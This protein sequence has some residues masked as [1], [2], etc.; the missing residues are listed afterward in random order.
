MRTLR[1]FTVGAL[2]ALVSVGSLA[3]GCDLNPYDLSERGQN[4]DDDDDGGMGDDGDVGDDGGGGDDGGPG[5]S[6]TPIGVDDQCNEIDDDCDGVT[7]QGF[8]KQTNAN[9]CGVCNNRCIGTGAIQ[10]CEAGACAFDSCQPGFTDLDA[11]PLDC[12]YRCPQFPTIA[13]DCNGIDDDCNGIIDDN[14]PPPP[15]NECRNTANT[16]CANVTMVCDTRNAITQWYCDYS[17]DVEFDANVPDGI[18]LNETLC[19]GLDGDCDGAPDDAFPDKGDECDNGLFGVCRDVGVRICDTAMPTQT[20][21]DL[22]VL[23][24]AG[25]MQPETCN[26]LD[27]NCDNL[28]DNGATDSMT[29]VTFAG[30]DFFI[31]TY[32]ASHPDAT[33]TGTGVSTVRSCSNPGVLPWRG[34]THSAASAACAAAGKTLCTPARW[35]AACEQRAGGETSDRLWPYGNT[36]APSSCNTETYDGDAGTAGDQD[37]L[38]ATGA[39][40]TCASAMGVRDLSGNLREWTTETVVVGGITLGVQRGGSYLSPEVATTCAFRLTRA[41]VTSIEQDTGFRCCRTP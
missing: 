31:D 4:G 34:A 11:N 7:D 15:T 19:D 30:Q 18:V 16:P 36:F 9:H 26:G 8:D 38:I 25:T 29:R 20:R 2:L 1:L 5:P 39:L 14:L 3:V 28:V 24:D 17:A 32:E 21:C 6:C 35:E 12:E 41:G 22:T 33:A 13:E 10:K 40:P 23:P 37:L 27:D